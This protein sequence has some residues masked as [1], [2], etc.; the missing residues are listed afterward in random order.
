M[1]TATKATI[2]ELRQHLCLFYRAE[3]FE[4]IESLAA[5]DMTDMKLLNTRTRC[6]Y[7][8]VQLAELV[9]HARELMEMADNEITEAKS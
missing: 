2:A 6:I 3:M 7:E 5:M 4:A 9:K 8:P 1:S